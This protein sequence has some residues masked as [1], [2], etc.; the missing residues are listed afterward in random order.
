MLDP[1]LYKERAHRI[2]WLDS[3]DGQADLSL[4]WAH[5]P[6]HAFCLITAQLLNSRRACVCGGG[7]GLY[8]STLILPRR[9]QKVSK[10]GV[11]DKNNV[12]GNIYISQ[13]WVDTG[14]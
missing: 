6:T 11:C 14:I 1:W 13:L 2:L 9:D 12:Y 3:V 8:K 10:I 4:R 5:M 7:E